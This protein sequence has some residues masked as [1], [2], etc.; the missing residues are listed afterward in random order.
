M[1]LLHTGKVR[2]V[3]TDRRD[4][5]FL[6]DWSSG[7]DWDRTAPGPEIPAETVTTTRARYAEACQRLTGRRFT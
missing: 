1:E 6:R 7:L 2:D 3:Y 5:Q 4:K